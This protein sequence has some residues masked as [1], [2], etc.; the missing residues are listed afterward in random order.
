MNNSP[1]QPQKEK[2]KITRAEYKKLKKRARRARFLLFLLKAVAVIL[3]L[4]AV[5]FAVWGIT[6]T[7]IKNRKITY[8]YTIGLT[9]KTAEKYE[10]VQKT[11]KNPNAK[12]VG[13]YIDDIAEICGFS[14]SGNDKKRICISSRTDEELIFHTDSAQA[15]IN[16]EDIELSFIPVMEN[17][18]LL[19]PYDFIERYLNGF[20]ISKSGKSIKIIGDSTTPEIYFDPKPYTPSLSTSQSDSTDLTPAFSYKADLSD[21]LA[22]ISPERTDDFLILVNK[23][24]PIDESFIPSDLYDVENSRSGRTER[25]QRTAAMALE[26]LFLEAEANGINV[27]KNANGQ[28]NVMSGYRSYA[29]QEQIFNTYVQEKIDDGM[30]EDDAIREVL[31]FSAMPGTS[32]HQTGLCVDMHTLSSADESFKNTSEYKWLKENAHKFGFIIRFPSGK[33]DITGYSF[34]PWHYRYVGVYHATKI[35]QSGLCLE[36]YLPTLK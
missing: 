15:R 22:Y 17:K 21:Y 9:E 18:K 3:T 11:Y 33:E 19:V 13:V 4:G 28:L 30:S 1:A 27:G 29:Y 26:A 24:N 20:I 8:T 7:I 23:E 36:E 2:I 25:M 16:G 32:E 35:Y 6:T 14:V 10:R 34:E 5:A 12:L 31:T